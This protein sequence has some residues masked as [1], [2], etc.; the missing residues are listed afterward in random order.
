MARK[1]AEALSMVTNIPGQRPEPPASLSERQK[2]EWRA[3]VSRMPSDWF[4][5]ETHSL[6]MAFVAHVERLEEVNAVLRRVKLD[7]STVLLYKDLTLI[8]DREGRALGSL[9][10]RMRL[11]HQARHTHKT[12]ATAI[13]KA[14]T[15]GKPW[16]VQQF[17]Q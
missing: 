5:R 7:E 11:T 9:G 8:A 15:G 4:T 6:L 3:V 14:G 12:G 1:S 2:E 17:T 16:S 10:A 13:S